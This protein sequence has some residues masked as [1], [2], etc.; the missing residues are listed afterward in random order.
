M[1]K[2]FIALIG[3]IS[4]TT[5]LSAFAGPNWQVIDQERMDGAK[6]FHAREGTSQAE[7]C[8]CPPTQG[9]NEKKQHK[10]VNLHATKKPILNAVSK[11][12]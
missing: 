4:A 2:I 3:I 10:L 11:T 6:M 7:G 12:S 5:S 1:N 8:A 9:L